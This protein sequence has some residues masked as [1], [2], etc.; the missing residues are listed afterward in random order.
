VR[1]TTASSG[2]SATIVGNLGAYGRIDLTFSARGTK[3]APLGC[4]GSLR[5]EHSG[6]LSGTFHFATQSSYFLTIDKS[7]FRG[8]TATVKRGVS[9]RAP[10][11]QLAPQT[12]LNVFSRANP[13]TP[14]TT[15]QIGFDVA[16]DRKGH[17]AE[18]F[19]IIEPRSG[20]QSPTILHSIYSSN[21]PAS[22]FINLPDVSSAQAT[23]SGMF[24]SGTLTYTSKK[25]ITPHRTTGSVTGSIVAHFD[26]L[27]PVML[28]A[29]PA[30]YA[31]LTF[32]P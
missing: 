3:H 14:A 26:G 21:L 12:D 28:P 15:R 17:I 9:C 27:P 7:N 1:V 8:Y 16:R 10:G 24:M 2:G 11:G 19:S 22:A 13:A 31:F 25:R 32:Q 29:P 23:A 18:F 5:F 6:P 4:P 30:T 20:R